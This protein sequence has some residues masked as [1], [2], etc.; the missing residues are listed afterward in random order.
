M[1]I[2][3][4]ISTLHDALKKKLGLEWV[5]GEELGGHT[6][7]AAG[8]AA[9]EVSLVGNLNLI[10]QHRIQVL[11]TKELEYLDNLK[12]NSRKDT[13]SQ[14]FSGQS[15]L[16]IIA[17]R[18]EAPGDLVTRPPQA[19]YRY[20]P[21]ACPARKPFSTCVIFSAITFE[22]TPALIFM[23]VIKPELALSCRHAPSPDR[24]MLPSS[25]RP[26][27]WNGTARKCCATSEV[28]TGDPQRVCRASA[29]AGPQP[30][31]Y[32]RSAGNGEAAAMDRSRQQAHT[33][34]HGRRY[35]NHPPVG[36]GRNSGCW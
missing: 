27:V 21:P 17:R 23:E 13:I 10:N 35:R 19:G 24:H 22:K 12:K 31:A 2:T 11:G 16:V 14:L 6:I 8:D 7:Q 20:C 4:L 30:A 3:L 5:T 1:S 34:H 28:R 33:Y 25:L 26:D 15:D 32:H 18:L 36:P 9:A 29:I